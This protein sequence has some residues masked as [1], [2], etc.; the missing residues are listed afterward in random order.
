MLSKMPAKQQKKWNQGPTIK[1]TDNVKLDEISIA[2][3]SGSMRAL[4]NLYEALDTGAVVSAKDF[5][6]NF[7]EHMRRVGSWKNAV[8]KSHGAM[9]ESFPVFH[10]VLEMLHSEPQSE[11]D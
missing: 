9:A 6:T 1:R 8:L 2:E 3:D 7:C 11:V 4:D 10:R 5:Q